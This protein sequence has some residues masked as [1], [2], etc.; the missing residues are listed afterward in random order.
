M[1]N[2]GILIP[3]LDP[4]AQLLELV[5]QLLAQQ[6]ALAS[7]VVVDDGSDAKHQPIFEQLQHLD[8]SRVHLLRHA[9]NQGKGAALK[10]GFRYY[11]QQT[12]LPAL[13]GIATM[14]ADGQHTVAALEKCLH[15]ATQ[16]PDDLIIGAR[17]FTGD[18]PWRSRFGNILTDNLVRVLT[19]QTISDTQTGLRVIPWTYLTTALTFPGERFEFEFDMLLEAKKHHV[20]ISEQPIPTIYLDGNASSHFR[21]VRDSL[22]IY[23]RFFK[24]AAS[25]LASFVIDIGLFSLFMLLLGQQQSLAVIMGATVLARLASAVVNYQINRHVVFENAGER[26]LWKYGLLLVLQTLASG[27]LTHGLTE[28]LSIVWQSALTPTVAKLVG[29]F[30]LFLLSYYLQKNFIFKRRSHVK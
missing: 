7:I 28:L 27:Y 17:Q 4:D 19:H 15:L 23:A 14:D 18:I 22:A 11:L 6:P 29:D 1:L 25:G 3:A 30:C 12:N 21:V 8:D 16:R 24:F 20:T 26:T 13:A 5:R 10:T 2:F 9:Q